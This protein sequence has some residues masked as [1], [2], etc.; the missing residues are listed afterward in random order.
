LF[1][2]MLIFCGYVMSIPSLPFCNLHISPTT[3]EHFRRT[4]TDS[5][6]LPPVF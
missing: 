1:P 5:N 3:K 4:Y 2:L 6:P